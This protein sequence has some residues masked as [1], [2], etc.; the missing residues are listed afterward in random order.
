MIGR[1]TTGRILTT[2]GFA[3]ADLAWE[4][5]IFNTLGAE[6]PHVSTM[7]KLPLKVSRVGSSL[8]ISVNLSS[9][10]EKK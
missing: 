6:T 7:A 8:Q 9:D 4:G 3:S 5:K 2:E 1:S 10:F